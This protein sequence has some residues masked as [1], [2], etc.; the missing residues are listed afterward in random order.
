VDALARVAT[1]VRRIRAE[2]PW[3]VLYLDAGDVEE[4]TTWISSVTKGAGMHRLLRAAGCNAAAVGN[5][6]WLRYGAHAIE[7]HAAAAGYPILCANLVPIPGA[8][9]AAL[10][11]A[12]DER[13]GVIGVTAP[14]DD[15]RSNFDFG[16]EAL[17]PLPLVLEH[18][19]ALRAGGAGL[20]VL[21]SH[22]GLDTPAEPVD[23][24]RL[25]PEIAG[26]VDLVIGAHSH[27]LFP[28]GERIAGIL[29]AQAGEYAQHL[30]RVDVTSDGARAS[31]LTVGDDVPPDPE[32]LG[33]L[34]AVEADIAAYLDEVIGE[35]PEPLGLEAATRWL[36]E[37]LRRRMGAEVGLATPG[38]AFDGSLPGGPLRR[39]D[40]WDVCPSPGNPGVV[41]VTGEQLALMLARGRDPEFAETTP[42]PLRGR[43]NGLLQAVGA[44]GLDP[45]RRYA[46]AG[47]DWELD[48]LGGVTDPDWGL[49]PRYDFPVIVREAIEEHLRGPSGK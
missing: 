30:G 17:D 29:V 21:L 48:R 24:R 41:E 3:P 1:L 43:P 11:Q 42:R 33:V 27:Q 18:A 40:L 13:V 26:A 6:V 7:S 44:D 45:A 9:P 32:V 14:F 47:T 28:D 31:V 10:L 34:T 22:L 37:I 8:V 19:A 16:V 46:V 5:A 4:T 15:M 23:D 49:R 39:R 38:A 35:L 25:V 20:V 12:G 2:T 36:A